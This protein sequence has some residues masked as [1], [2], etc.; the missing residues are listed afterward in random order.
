V[1]A[2]RSP[3]T[4]P[5]SDLQQTGNLIRLEDGTIVLPFGHK[6]GPGVGKEDGVTGQRA[7]VSYDRGVTWSRLV[8]DLHVGGLYASSAVARDG[9]IVTMWSG[10]GD[11]DGGVMEAMR[12][13]LPPRSV[14]APFGFFTPTAVDVDGSY[15]LDDNPQAGA[16]EAARAQIAELQ[17]RVAQLEGEL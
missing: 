11:S 14:V 2:C 15:W 4:I 12:W 9:A 10:S 13:R 1:H 16:L 8:L 6:N 5:T 3:K 17:A 7:I